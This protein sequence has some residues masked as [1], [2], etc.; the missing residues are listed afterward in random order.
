MDLYSATIGAEARVAVAEARIDQQLSNRRGLTV[1]QDQDCE[2]AV[3]AATCARDYTPAV[4]SIPSRDD[5]HYAGQGRLVFRG[6]RDYYRQ[7]A[8]S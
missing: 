8:W 1:T 4:D 7:D 5:S 2:R 6:T 3:F